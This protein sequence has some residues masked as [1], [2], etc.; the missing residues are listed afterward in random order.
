MA[1]EVEIAVFDTA[2]DELVWSATIDDLDQFEGEIPLGTFTCNGDVEVMWSWV[3]T[4]PT[5]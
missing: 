2:T 1:L 3:R 4:S 5:L